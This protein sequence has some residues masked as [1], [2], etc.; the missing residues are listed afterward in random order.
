MKQNLIIKSYL[1][2][3]GNEYDALSKSLYNSASVSSKASA[4]SIIVSFLG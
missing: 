2:F 1:L 3:L 4:K